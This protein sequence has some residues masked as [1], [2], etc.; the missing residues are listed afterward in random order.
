MTEEGRD[1]GQLSQ[2]LAILNAAYNRKRAFR[3][4]INESLQRI[5][6]FQKDWLQQHPPTTR[7]SVYGQPNPLSDTDIPNY[8]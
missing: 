4:P 7:V 1:S 3:D 2:I 6:A 8:K 5:H